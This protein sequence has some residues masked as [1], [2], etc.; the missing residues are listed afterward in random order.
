MSKLRDRAKRAIT[1]QVDGDAIALGFPT[2]ALKNKLLA[3]SR[4]MGQIDPE[5]PP[6]DF[7][8]LWD[9]ICV[10]SLNSTLLDPDDLDYEDVSRLLVQC[11]EGEAKGDGSTDELRNLFD[12]ALSLCGFQIDRDV[13]GTDHVK[14]AHEAGGDTPT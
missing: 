8:E 6:A 3:Q 10:S 9:D 1:V 13:E 11:R 7:M 12:A 4:S 2:S 5:N 14:N